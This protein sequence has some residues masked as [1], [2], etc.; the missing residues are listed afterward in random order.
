MWYGY[1]CAAASL[2]KCPHF[3][4][5]VS[6]VFAPCIYF[7]VDWYYNI[8]YFLE[9]IVCLYGC[10]GDTSDT[11]F[12]DVLFG[13]RADLYVDPSSAVVEAVELINTGLCEYVWESLDKE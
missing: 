5:N 4:L 6:N 10:D 13:G 2:L 3:S 9:F 8:P 7:L 11:K 12:V 1:R